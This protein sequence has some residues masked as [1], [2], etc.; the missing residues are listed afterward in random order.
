MQITRTQKSVCEEFE[1][2]HLGAYHDMY[3]QSGT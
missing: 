3:V 2:N 1:A